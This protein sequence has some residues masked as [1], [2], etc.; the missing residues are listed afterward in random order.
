MGRARTGGVGRSSQHGEQHRQFAAALTA[1]RLGARTRDAAHCS[2][3]LLERLDDQDVPVVQ[4][5]V[6]VE[7]TRELDAPLL[8][9]VQESADFVVTMRRRNGES[10]RRGPTKWDT[11]RSW[12][13]R[14]ADRS[15]CTAGSPA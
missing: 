11:D 14:C 5:V 6:V 9:P 13:S 2:Q 3:S 7:E 15:R 1:A 4:L 8:N 12:C 10:H